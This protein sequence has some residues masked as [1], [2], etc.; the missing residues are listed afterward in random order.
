VSTGR[1]LFLVR[2]GRSDFSSNDMT[3]TPRGHQFD[4]PLSQVGRQ[5]AALLAKRLLLLDPQPTVVYCS[6]LRRCRETVA[7]YA[8]AS[9]A[10]VRFD[11]DLVEA[12]IGEWENK[13]FEEILE[14]ERMLTRL[15]NQE[16]IWSHAPGAEDPVSFR[17]RIRGA[18]ERI[19]AEDRDGNVLVVCH[20][21]VINAYLGP[22]LGIDRDMF[23]LPE[24]T[25]VNSV[26]VEGERRSVRFLND[27]V[28]L[29]DP[30]LLGLD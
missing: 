13:P 27:V 17:E 24:N 15:R 8:A 1:V 21:G 3:L 4:P 29:T 28:H 19:L 12:H 7:P 14:D 16:P 5:Q 2:H 25:S 26:A 23:F 22:I 6:P 10:D 20:G 18:V 9:G 30:H 11:E